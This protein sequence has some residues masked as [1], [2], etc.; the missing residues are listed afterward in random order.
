MAE[1]ASECA[2]FNVFELSQYILQSDCRSVLRVLHHL[3]NS[4][5]EP[6]LVLWLLARECRELL[7]MLEQLE[8]G[9]PLAAVLAAQWSNLKTLYQTALKRVTLTQ[10]KQLLLDCQAADQIIKGVSSGCIWDTLT[11]ISLALAGKRLCC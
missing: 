7:N 11:Q 3:K 5:V 10:L 6:T 1:A 9:K 4:D 2:Q 8:Q